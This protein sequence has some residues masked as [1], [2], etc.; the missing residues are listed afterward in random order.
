MLFRLF[1]VL[2]VL[3]S[4]YEA[5]LDST[6][7]QQKGLGGGKLKVH[8]SLSPTYSPPFLTPLQDWG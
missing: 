7:M 5:C 8:K 6:G 3:E 4:Q 1:Y 2:E